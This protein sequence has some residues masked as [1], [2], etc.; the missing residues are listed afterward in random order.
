[1]MDSVFTRVLLTLAVIAALMFIA[2]L[3]RRL[4]LRFARRQAYKPGRVFQV[5]AVIN[6]VATLLGLLGISIIW[7]LTGHSL[8]VVASSIFALV[9]VA[10]FASWSLLSNATAAM[11]LFFSAPFR[12]GDRIRLLDGDN[13]VTGRV[14]DMGL[15]YLQM[16]DEL[17]H[18]YTLPNNLLT[19]RAVIRLKDDKELPCEPKHARAP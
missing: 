5:T 11:I 9:G 8:V 10:L 2:S 1:M 14:T 16:E 15:F 19:Q 7:G 6:L 4:L 3:L 13:T 17:G 12:V 18:L